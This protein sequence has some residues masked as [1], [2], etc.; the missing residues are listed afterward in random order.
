MDASYFIVQ[1]YLNIKRLGDAELLL[2]FLPYT[3]ILE[4]VSDR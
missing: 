2:T 3:D 1:S 4:F